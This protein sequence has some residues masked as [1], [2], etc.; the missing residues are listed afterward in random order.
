MNLVEWCNHCILCGEMEGG[1]DGRRG[2]NVRNGEVERF[3]DKEGAAWGKQKEIRRP[4]K[5]SPVSFGTWAKL[6][7][8]LHGAFS[9]EPS[10]SAAY[11]S[12]GPFLTGKSLSRASTPKKGERE[13]KREISVNDYAT[14]PY[15]L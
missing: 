2:K 6:D 15:S 12:G 10:N 7:K 5:V 4:A 14:L 13:V 9:Y 3:F 1:S 8:R 11:C